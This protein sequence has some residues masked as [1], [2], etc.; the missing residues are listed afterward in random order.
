MEIFNIKMRYKGGDLMALSNGWNEPRLCVATTRR[1]FDLPSRKEMGKAQVGK[2]AQYVVSVH[3]RKKKHGVAIR[4]NP[5]TDKPR[6]ISPWWGEMDERKI[7]V[8]RVDGEGHIG[9]S[10]LGFYYETTDKMKELFDDSGKKKLYIVI[11]AV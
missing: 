11:E 8:E 6:R 10:N 1:F 2:D 9:W 3:D 7:Q 4:V 5:R